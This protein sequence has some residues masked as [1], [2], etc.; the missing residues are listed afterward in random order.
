MSA[1]KICADNIQ[2]FIPINKTNNRAPILWTAVSIKL[3]ENERAG[4]TR[5]A[6]VKVVVH[7]GGSDENELSLRVSGTKSSLHGNRIA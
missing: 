2:A 3:F 7:N 5:F 1:F 4:G 6:E